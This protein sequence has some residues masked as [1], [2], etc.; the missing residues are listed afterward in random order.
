MAGF[1]TFLA[2]TAVMGLS[3]FLSLPIVFSR[4]AQGR[5]AVGLNAAA[6]GI[7]IFLLADVFSDASTVLYPNG[8]VANLG[9]SLAFGSAF[10]GAFLA[11]YLV[12]NLRRGS[13]GSSS[14]ARPAGAPGVDGTRRPRP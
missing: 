6:I 1:A 12:D 8:Y 14:R 11:L 3:I 7:L 5:W 13:V 4:R 10:V 2:L 9:Y